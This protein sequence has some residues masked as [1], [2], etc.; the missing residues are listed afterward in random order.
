M[1]VVAVMLLLWAPAGPRQASTACCLPALSG[2]FLPPADF[3]LQM[4][5]QVVKL[6]GQVLSVMYRFRTKNR[7]WVLIRTSSFTFQNPY[8]DEIE[9][10]ICT[11][12]NVKY[13]PARPSPGPSRRWCSGPLSSLQ[14]PALPAA[15]DPCRGLRSRTRGRLA[16][17]HYLLPGP[18]SQGPPDWEPSV[19]TDDPG[20][21]PSPSHCRSVQVA[22]VSMIFSSPSA[23]PSR[24]ELGAS[25][26]LPSVPAKAGR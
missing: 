26:G 6:K 25:L 15:A 24:V 2:T 17:L 20:G 4:F 18:P 14:A 5:A 23:G 21:T 19:L 1:P 22:L 12:T 16:P 10:I 11:N 9:Y 13:V 8:S 3:L 7:E